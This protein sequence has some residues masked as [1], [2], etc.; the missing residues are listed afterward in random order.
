MVVFILLWMMLAF[1]L[2]TFYKYQQQ[3]GWRTLNGL[4]VLFSVCAGLLLTVYITLN[5]GIY[6]T[7][8]E[9]FEFFDNFTGQNLSEMTDSECNWVIG[10]IKSM[11]QV[12]IN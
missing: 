10:L 12:K 1:R 4:S 9:V 7:D 3:H 6:G 5:A 11:M 2:S 8:Q